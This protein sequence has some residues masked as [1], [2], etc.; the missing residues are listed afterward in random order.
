MTSL[1][2]FHPKVVEWFTK[3]LGSPTDIQLKAW[4]SIQ[5][6]QHTLISAPTGSGKTLAAFLS[7]IDDMIKK[8]LDGELSDKTM[9]VYVS[10]LKALSNDIHKNLQIPL[11]GIKKLFKDEHRHKVDIKVA[12]RTGD[13]T[14]TQ[15]TS[16]YKHPPHILVTTPESLYLLLTSVNGRKMLSSVKTVIVDE[17]HAIL[18]SKRGSHLALSIERLQQL[19]KNSLTRIGLSATQKPIDTVAEFLTGS[20]RCN[21]INAG[22]SRKMDIAIEVTG[23]PLESVMSNEV[24]VEIYQRLEQLINQHDTTLIFVNT[25][26]LAERMAHRLT[27][28]MGANLINAHHGSMSKEHRL[29]AEQ[30]LKSGKLKALIA[31]ASM[32][33]GIDIGT[34]DLVCQMGSPRSIANFLQR[35]GRSGHSIDGIPKGRLFPL[36]RDELV[37]S[38]ALM[39]ALKLN[40]LDSL[41]IPEKTPGRPCSANSSRSGQ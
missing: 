30:K 14:S 5:K 1:E 21:I 20:Q 6:Q 34:V 22:H 32:E 7:I 39:Q 10:P 26:R 36:S 8:G 25:R 37:E 15:R 24:W 27:E 11:Q 3:H 23:S 38:A 33:L 28:M 29:E 12:L 16:M 4:P 35:V 2:N 40:E 18:Q 13:T 41:E 9:V 31:T 17:I 19:C